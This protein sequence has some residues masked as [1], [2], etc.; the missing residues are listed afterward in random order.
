M[1][2]SNPDTLALFTTLLNLSDIIVTEIRN[3]PNDRIVTFVVKSTREILPC[4]IC[5]Q[6]TKGHGLGRTLRLRHLAILGKETY[7]EITPRRGR[8]EECE[9][10]PTTTE[11]LDW[12]D[13]HSKMT[14]PFE[15]HLLFELIN[16]TVSD[17]SR[18]ENVDY[19]AVAHL[20]DGYIDSDINFSQIEALG[21]LGLDE[22]SL[23]KG[24][25][26]FVTLFTYRID[27]KVNILGVVEG[28]EK[29]DIIAF[30]SKIPS[31]LQDTIQAVCCDLYDG[32]M[33]ACKAVFK[34]NVPVVAD[35]FHVRKLYRKSLINLRKSELARLRKALSDVDYAQLKP[36]ITLLRKQ[37]D[38][39]TDAEKSMVDKLFSLSPK[40]KLAYQFSRDLSGLFDSHI[41]PEAAKE[42]LTVWIEA[43][44]HSG[45]TC[46]NNFIKT[47]KKYQVQITN[48]FI[49]R[50]NSGF[51]EG[52]NNKV[53]VLKRRCYGLSSKTKLFQRLVLDTMG[54]LW[55][56]PGVAA[57]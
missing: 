9:D 57:F 21:V 4:R 47:L 39:F 37:K 45:L 42:N 35:R 48:Y 6:P 30:L 28:R 27:N 24:Y 26:D 33:N 25:R 49:Q 44:T 52:F 3:P 53:K 5:G 14:K 29:A 17:V 54:L 7:I 18:K 22:I 56:S 2:N 8:C 1:L 19:H 38:Y 11:Q 16:S 15:H 40:L 55:F 10:H 41:T 36:A 50:N 43:V 31:R 12:Y 51:V 34:E 20:I 13:T 46:F 32:Y 23:K